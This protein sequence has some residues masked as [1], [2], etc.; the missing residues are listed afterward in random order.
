MAHVDEPKTIN[1][2]IELSVKTDNR[3][4]ERRRDQKGGNSGKESSGKSGNSKKWKSHGRYKS[5]ETKQLSTIRK[6]SNKEKTQRYEGKLYFDYG[7]PGY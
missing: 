2:V 4:Y 6:L 1:E 3:L 7:K 5:E